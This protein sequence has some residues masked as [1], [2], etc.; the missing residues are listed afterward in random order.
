MAH[1]F[2]GRDAFLDLE[3]AGEMGEA[4]IADLKGGFGD[5]ASAVCDQAGGVVDACTAEPERQGNA[6]HLGK[7]AAQVVR[8]TTCPSSEFLEVRRIIQLVE[9]VGLDLFHTFPG[10]SLGPRQRGWGGGIGGGLEKQ[11]A[12]EKVGEASA[13]KESASALAEMGSHKAASPVLVLGCEGAAD[14]TRRAF[15]GGN[16]RAERMGDLVME[17]DEV[18]LEPRVRKDEGEAFLLLARGGAGGGFEAACPGERLGG[19]GAGG[20]AAV[21]GAKKA[22]A[23]EIEMEA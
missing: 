8:T 20:R 5:V 1:P 23:A 6:G 10:D 18:L 2:A 21:G 4:A 14:E 15:G 3:G 22:M 13:V 17:I 7:G 16:E 19:D 11:L 12:E 9:Q